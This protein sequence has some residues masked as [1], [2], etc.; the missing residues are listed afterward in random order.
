MADRIYTRRVGTSAN[1]TINGDG[2]DDLMYGYGGNDTL[3][4]NGGNDRLLGGDGDDT[5]SGGIGNDDLFG[6]KGADKIY[7]GEGHDT[8]H[9]G[10]GSDLMDG[11]NGTDMVDYQ[12]SATGVYVNLD[13][14]F[15]GLGDA[16]GDR[17]V[18]IEQV[19]GSR[20]N[21]TII[22]GRDNNW[23]DGN[24]GDDVID[25]RS[26]NDHLTGGGGNDT[27]IGGAGADQMYGQLGNDWVDYSASPEINYAVYTNDIGMWVSLIHNFGAGGHAE[28]DTFS[29]I[30]N[31]RGSRGAD[32][33]IGNNMANTIE[34]GAGRDRLAGLGGNDTLNGGSEDDLI[35]G[36]SGN[37]IMTGGDGADTFRFELSEQ[38]VPT[39][40]YDEIMDF[41]IGVDR[42][43]FGGTGVD[44]MSDLT[45]QQSWGR[46]VISFENNYGQI[47]HIALYGVGANQ[48]TEDSFLFS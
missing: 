47:E 11:G 26:G 41:T 24:E 43:D 10:E 44:A 31:V 37:D 27:F 42:I 46:A 36:G 23:I 13:V 6:D 45:I 40:G 4:G 33:I 25:G 8:L 7:G 32:N 16:Q 1:D 9:G 38:Y 21:D 39:A 17:Y 29:D 35:V 14:G 34:G 18:S 12:A 5:L 22:G 28:G 30:E 15:G 3:N 20:F 2:T 19:E 48:L